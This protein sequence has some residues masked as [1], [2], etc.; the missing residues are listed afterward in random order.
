M[1]DEFK[2]LN[3]DDTLYETVIPD[4]YR[5]TWSPPNDKLINAFIPGTVIEIKTAAGQKV[6]QGEVLLILDAM[7]MYNEIA[8]PVSGT[9]A[10]VLVQAGNHVVKNQLLIELE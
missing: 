7:K 2:K 3:I 6:N 4:S 8:A 1:S 10:K 5:R 9:I